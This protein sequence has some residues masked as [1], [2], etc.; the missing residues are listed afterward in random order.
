LPG[1]VA[2]TASRRWKSG[3][4]NPTFLFGAGPRGIIFFVIRRFYVHNYRCLENF[5]LPLS[6][7][8]SLLLIGR[9]GAGKTTIGH[10]LEVLQKIAR[11]TNRVGDLVKPKE[12]R[13][14]SIPGRFI[15]AR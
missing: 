2:Q 11:G 5:D 7:K 15:A 3:R 4:G 14:V 12:K 6:G 13:R 10:A 1:R 8:S 9:N